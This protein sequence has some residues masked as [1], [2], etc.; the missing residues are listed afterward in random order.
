MALRRTRFDEHARPPGAS[1]IFVEGIA[2]HPPV[3]ERQ[4][5]KL[6]AEGL[7]ADDPDGLLAA[8]AMNEN[9]WADTVARALRLPQALLDEKVDGEWSFLETLRHLVHVTDAWILRTV[10]GNPHPFHTWGLPPHF[11]N[12]R[13]LGLDL[14]A[15]PETQEVL[16]CRKDRLSRV[17]FY[18]ASATAENLRRRCLGGWTALGAVQ[19]VMFEEW[20]H[21][22]YAIR[23][24][25]R[26]ETE[27][28]LPTSPD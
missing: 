24:L 13:E 14:D 7:L 1:A 27:S 4:A 21:R 20:A 8:W 6:A 19:V 15:R 26:L 17:R 23:D 3:V 12:G 11:V 16:S 28:G 25:R 10:Q 18:L 22:Q 9:A 2:A 5:Q